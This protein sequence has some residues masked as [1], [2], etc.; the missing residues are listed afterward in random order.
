[1]IKQLICAVGALLLIVYS[2]GAQSSEETSYLESI[3][4]GDV[5]FQDLKTSQS[6]AIKLATQSEYTHCGVV[7]ESDG[8]LVV[9]EA[10]Q[11][12]IV[13]P[14]DVWVDRGIDSFF[15][16]KRLLGAD[17]LLSS[18][19]LD[20]MQA[21]G[22]H[23]LGRDYDIYFNWSDDQLYCSELVWKVYNQGAG[24]VLVEPRLMREY[25]LSNPAVQAKMKER[26]GDNPPL[27]HPMVAPGDLFNSEKLNEVYRSVPDTIPPENIDDLG[28]VPEEP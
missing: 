27:D 26:Y 1:M 28:Q 13:T 25:D 11:P 17:S 23:Y 22:R 3:R 2:S 24:V 8:K 9:Y 16:A 7:F 10:V 12:V 15:V 19:S 21:V 6:L 20:S 4:P 18:E 14:L 5:V